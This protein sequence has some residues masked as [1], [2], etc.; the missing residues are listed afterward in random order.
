MWVYDS[1][2]G[3]FIYLFIFVFFVVCY[4]SEETRLVFVGR[5]YQAVVEVFGHWDSKNLPNA[6]SGQVSKSHCSD[7]MCSRRLCYYLEFVYI[8]NVHV[9]IVRSCG[10]FTIIML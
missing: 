10:F 8:Y 6:C 4:D 3:I 7:F 2:R 5:G 1:G 9:F